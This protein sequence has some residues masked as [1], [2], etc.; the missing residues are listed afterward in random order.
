MS[1][2]SLATMR[3]SNE[4]LHG[5]ES[6]GGKR[7]AAVKG[8]VGP[9]RSKRRSRGCWRR[10]STGQD[11]ALQGR[12][13]REGPSSITELAAQIRGVPEHYAEVLSVHYAERVNVCEQALS[14]CAE[15]LTVCAQELTVREAKVGH[16]EFYR[17]APGSTQEMRKGFGRDEV[18]LPLQYVEY[19]TL[20]AQEL[21]MY[22]QELIVR[23]VNVRQRESYREQAMQKTRKESTRT[24]GL[25]DAVQCAQELPVRE[26]QTRK[27]EFYREQA[28]QKAKKKS[29]RARTEESEGQREKRLLEERLVHLRKLMLS[30]SEDY[31]GLEGY[32]V[33]VN[34]ETHLVREGES[35]EEPDEAFIAHSRGPVGYEEYRPS[36][37]DEGEAEGEVEVV[38]SAACDGT[39]SETFAWQHAPREEAAKI[40]E[41]HIAP[42][43]VEHGQED[44]DGVSELE[45]S[46]SSMMFAS[47]TTASPIVQPMR[48][49]RERSPGG[50]FAVEEKHVTEHRAQKAEDRMV[51]RAAD[52]EHV[53]D[54]CWKSVQS[55]CIR[56][57][58]AG[59]TQ[60]SITEK[61]LSGAQAIM[62]VA[63]K[64]VVA[65]KRELEE[66][67]AET[68]ESETNK[69][70]GE[71]WPVMFPGSQL[72]GAQVNAAVASEEVVA[73]EQDPDKA[74]AETDSWEGNCAEIGV[75]SGLSSAT[76]AQEK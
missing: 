73:S 59:P 19:Q 75:C 18:V 4:I 42:S 1:A 2:S 48:Q 43:C 57:S 69:L 52:W 8:Q 74:E 16:V 30:G 22:A 47:P 35:E 64:E 38:S 3:G 51:S 33:P 70:V 11:R 44:Y 12:G 17:V 46:R 20:Y 7:G 9:Q 32:T 55:K 66:A 14:A 63:S 6:N 13:L 56:A 53:I 23:E 65:S 60:A 76:E 71:L 36:E 25:G 26:K 68:D 21:D 72:Y 40:E 31:T 67:E 28:M 41:A 49:E 50:T 58:G 10:N 34:R 54:A 5:S 29:G 24:S 45:K 39:R 62:T 15:K 61:E 37:K 27:R